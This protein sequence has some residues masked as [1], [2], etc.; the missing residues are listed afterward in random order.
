ML[1]NTQGIANKKIINAEGDRNVVVKE[2]EAATVSKINKAQADAQALLID[3][4]KK[5]KV[6]SIEETAKL[7]DVQAKYQTLI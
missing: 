5:T 4:D 2:V 7:A 3:T 6:M 1:T